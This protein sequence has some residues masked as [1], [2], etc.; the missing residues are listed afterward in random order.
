MPGRADLSGRPA[1]RRKAKL[2]ASAPA[3]CVLC[4]RAIDLELSGN[5]KWGPT[6]HH[7]IPV[8]LGGHPTAPENQALAHRQC[9]LK[10]GA[11]PLREARALLIPKQRATLAHSRKWL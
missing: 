1:R 8:V 9:N 2:L 6:T 3:I 10:A 5:H 4:D 11:K 7:L